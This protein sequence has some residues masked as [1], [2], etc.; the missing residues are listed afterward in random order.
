MRRRRGA[1]RAGV[2]AGLTLALFLPG[3]ALEAQGPEG[4][5]RPGV[6]ATWEHAYVVLPQA[7]DRRVTGTLSGERIRETLAALPP[8]RKFPAVL[9]LHGCAGMGPGNFD[10]MYLL[11]GQGYAVVAPD[12]FAREYRP[13][14]CDP[15]TQRGIPGA[16]IREVVV[17][18]VREIRYALEQI[19]RLA[20]VDQ[21]NVFLMG[22]SQ[23]GGAAAVFSGRGFNGV[24]VSGTRCGFG[25]RTPPETPLLTIYS[26]SD[27]W[28][29]GQD[30]RGCEERAAR[31]GRTIEFH[32]FEGSAHVLAGN[33][34]ARDL[35]RAFLKRHT[36]SSAP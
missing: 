19:Q 12:S 6:K 8:G 26:E 3:C 21:K 33:E 11:A 2:L 9:Y 32:L 20:W 22:Q 36:R 17:M 29:Q 1:W 14:T 35:I 24:I 18:R 5:E 31:A 10:Y 34:R 15:R 7:E 30:P 28:G 13:L 25:L 27:P 4:Q 23:G 16:P